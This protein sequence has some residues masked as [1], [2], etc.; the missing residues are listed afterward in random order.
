MSKLI[1]HNIL[2]T[3]AGSGLGQHI[4]LKLNQ[5]GNR[6]ILV[7]RNQA[8]LDATRAQMD[9]P[10][11]AECISYDLSED[12]GAHDKW[13][14]D[15]TAKLGPLQGLVC[16]AGQQYISPVITLKPERVRALFEINL[17]A[18]MF[19]ARGFADK[20]VNA[21]TGSSIVFV[22]SVSANRGEKGLSA[23][24]ASKSALSGFVTS[25]AKEVADRGIR[26]NIVTPGLIKTPMIEAEDKVYTETFL[27]NESS[28]YPLGLGSPNAVS[29]AVEF[30]LSDKSY[31]S[32]GTE[33][34]VDGGFL[35]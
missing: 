13:L 1:G 29:N 28:K 17:F 4:A 18:H 6:T 10:E 14:R 34:V 20:R 16:M 12:I 31:W 25:Y 3:G 35:A 24:A 23:Y 30:L 32:T 19:L 22:S 11:R 15:L 21:G 33:I 5:A 8:K 27:A 9:K 7:G 2:V 26:A